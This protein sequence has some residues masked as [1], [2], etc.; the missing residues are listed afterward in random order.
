MILIVLAAVLAIAPPAPPKKLN[1]EEMARATFICF[2]YM[3]LETFERCM[4]EVTERW[5]R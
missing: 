3:D 1:A 2:R 4:K 5:R